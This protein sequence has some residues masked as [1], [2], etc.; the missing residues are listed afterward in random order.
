MP[1]AELDDGLLDVLIV[2]PVSRF[3]VA[4]TIGM[5]KKGLHAQLPELISW[6]RC[7][8]VAVRAEKPAAV[9]LDGE[10]LTQ[11]ESTFEIAPFQIRFAYPRGLR[12]EA[13]HSSNSEESGAFQSK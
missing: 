8:S 9:N 7:R 2:K 5:Y 1:E 3:R 4:R 13:L 6:R 11:R 12:C 10:L